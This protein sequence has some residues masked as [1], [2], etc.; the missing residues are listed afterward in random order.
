MREIF[1]GC[2]HHSCVDDRKLLQG[3]QGEK[4]EK[5]DKGDKGDPLTWEDLTQAQKEEIR[6][7]VGPQ[8][9]QGDKGQKGEAFTYDDFTED[10]L[11]QLRGP[12]GLRG[13]K[14]DT[15][16]KGDRG[17]RGPQGIPGE[18]GP[19]GFKGEPL[20][21]A[22]L[23][24]EQKDELRGEQGPQ[25]LGLVIR[26]RMDTVGELKTTKPHGEYGDAYLIGEDVWFW[27]HNKEEWYLG[28]QWKGD[29]GGPEGRKR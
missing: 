1:D 5:G 27:D 20:R 6:G 14:G 22:D 21:Y 17:E 7:E 29:Q 10:Q 3:P 24:E 4:G 28:G 9:P 2:H 23:T 26:G 11:E 25:G 15:G 13:E 18:Q 16:D 12:R 19:R 8:G